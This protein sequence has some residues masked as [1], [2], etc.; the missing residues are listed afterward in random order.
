MKPTK[1]IVFQNPLVKKTQ[2]NIPLSER[3]V[4]FHCLKLPKK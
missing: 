4:E 3:L 1:E 2:A